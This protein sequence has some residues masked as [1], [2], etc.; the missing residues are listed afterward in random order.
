MHILKRHFYRG[1]LNDEDQDKPAFTIPFVAFLKVIITH[2]KQQDKMQM[3]QN[4]MKRPLDGSDPADKKNKEDI[5]AD[6][7]CLKRP[8]VEGAQ[9]VAGLCMILLSTCLPYNFFD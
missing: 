2:K 3:R 5:A 1:P 8:R 4:I 7:A 9:V 6:I